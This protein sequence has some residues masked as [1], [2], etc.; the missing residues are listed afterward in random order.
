MP[1]CHPVGWDF[2]AM[3]ELSSRDDIDELRAIFV[4]DRRVQVPCFL[5]PGQALPSPI[6]SWRGATGA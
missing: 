3:F 4:A 2:A 6:T 5:L 1:E